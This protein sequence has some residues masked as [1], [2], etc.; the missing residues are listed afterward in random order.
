[1]KSIRQLFAL[2]IIAVS[3]AA[4]FG[5]IVG[6]VDGVFKDAALL[7]WICDRY[8]TASIDYEIYVGGPRGTANAQLLTP[9]ETALEISEPAVDEACGHAG[10]RASHRFLHIF[11]EAQ[12]WEHQGKSIYVH[13]V[14]GGVVD[15]QAIPNYSTITVPAPAS[16]G[17]STDDTANGTW[18][19]GANVTIDTITLW[20]SSEDTN[21]LY[22]KRSDG[23]SCYIPP[24]ETTLQSLILT[25]YSSG[26]LADIHCHAEA[27]VRAGGLSAH[28]L[29]RIIAK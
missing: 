14:R 24:G 3:P 23:V 1:M 4:A 18:N 6:N 29:H 19:F 25:L 22:F 11:T 17:G 2:I 20:A 12:K 10:S 16:G 27:E 9:R 13:G 7:G 15:N 28:K 26:E 5:D 21:P 8:S